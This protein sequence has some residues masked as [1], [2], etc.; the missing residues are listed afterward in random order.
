MEWKSSKLIFATTRSPAKLK[1]VSA[2]RFCNSH[3]QS[4]TKPKGQ[5][6][7]ISLKGHN[8]NRHIDHEALSEGSNFLLLPDR[9]FTSNPTH[10]RYSFSL[11]IRCL[12]FSISLWLFI[13]LANYVWHLPS[14]SLQLALRAVI[15]FDKKFNEAKFIY[16][17][18]MFPAQSTGF[19]LIQG[20]LYTEVQPVCKKQLVGL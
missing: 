20:T 11:G 14:T 4:C 8:R 13:L 1:E 12:R 10:I 3:S 17:C 9:I 5:H 6:E 15:W 16:D 2:K 18:K 7:P 19:H